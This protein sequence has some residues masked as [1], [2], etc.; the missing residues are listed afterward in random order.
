MVEEVQEVEGG[1]VLT[2]S[3]LPRSG[4]RRLH[5]AMYAATFLSLLR[6]LLFPGVS[7]PSLAEAAA[8]VEAALNAWRWEFSA[9]T[10]REALKCAGGLML[11]ELAEPERRRESRITP[12]CLLSVQ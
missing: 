8:A 6:P 9:M 11:P 10:T 12:F 2:S 3:A 1:S 7:N 4:R 5:A